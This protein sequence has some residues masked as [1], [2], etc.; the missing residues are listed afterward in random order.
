MNIDR[1]ITKKL[2]KVVNA[3][4]CLKS[5]HMYTYLL[6]LH[7]SVALI[8]TLPSQLVRIKKKIISTMKICPCL[9]NYQNLFSLSY[10]GLFH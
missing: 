7:I 5:L 10:H 8:L 6:I 9:K 3:S 1:A 4:Q 2:L